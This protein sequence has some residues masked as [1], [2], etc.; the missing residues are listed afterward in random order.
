MVIEQS[1]GVSFL[2]RTGLV[3]TRANVLRP[4]AVQSLYLERLT[5]RC[6]ALSIRINSNTTQSNSRGRVKGLL[7]GAVMVD[8][9]MSDIENL[10]T[11]LMSSLPGRVVIS[12]KLIRKGEGS[13]T[14][15]HG[16]YS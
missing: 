13:Q 7:V 1:M 11:N 4:P 6:D 8:E 3:A 9:Y 12:R 14:R 2:E 5:P 10:M 16:E 15:D